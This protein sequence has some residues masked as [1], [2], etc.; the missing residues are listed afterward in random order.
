MLV[1]FLGKRWN[2]RFVPNLGKNLGLCDAPDVKGKSILI[3][4]GIKGE[5]LLD[6]LIHEA[7]HACQ[8]HLR[9]ETVDEAASDLARMLWKLGYRKVGTD[10]IDQ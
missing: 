8:W 5:K 2:L 1:T 9:E 10:D 3:Q 4:G 7:L 6:T